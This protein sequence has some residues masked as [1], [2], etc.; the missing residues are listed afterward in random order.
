VN[1]VNLHSDFRMIAA[2]RANNAFVRFRNVNV[3]HMMSARHFSRFPVTEDEK[4]NSDVTG[5]K[6]FGIYLTSSAIGAFILN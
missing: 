3:D 6:L 5:L 1:N 2:S 4:V